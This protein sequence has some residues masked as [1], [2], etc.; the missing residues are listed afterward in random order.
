MTVERLGRFVAELLT[1]ELLP[2]WALPLSRFL[3]ISVHQASVYAALRISGLC[4]AEGAMM[5][6]RVVHDAASE[7]ISTL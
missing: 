2:S 4:W 6:L 5:D 3:S 7:T 1:Q